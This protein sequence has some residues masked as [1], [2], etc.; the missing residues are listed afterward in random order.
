MALVS[1]VDD[2]QLF[3]AALAVAL[4]ADGFDVHTPQLSSLQGVRD[5][6]LAR[7]PDVA[8]VDRDLGSLGSGEALLAPIARSGTSVI[9][10]SGTLDDVVVGRCLAAGAVGCLSK[11]EPFHVL[12]TAIG[13]A[14][15]GDAFVSQAERYRLI[16]AWRKWQASTDATADAFAHLTPREAVVLG[17]LMNG[18]SVKAIANEGVVSEATVRTQVRGILTKLDVTSQLEA[19]VMALRTGWRPDQHSVAGPPVP[20]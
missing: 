11:S 13:T 10:I 5:T 19:V 2:H 14:A 3:S 1:L 20:D 7:N 8:M 4:R 9:V 6:I 12:L 17:R 18:M 15:R 16:D